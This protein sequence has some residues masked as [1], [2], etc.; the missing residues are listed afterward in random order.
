MRRIIL[1]LAWGLTACI[2]L[3]S[4]VEGPESDA[5]QKPSGT[6]TLGLDETANC[7]EGEVGW[8]FATT[9]DP[10]STEYSRQA[11]ESALVQVAQRFAVSVQSSTCAGDASEYDRVVRE[12]EGDL[13]CRFASTCTGAFEVVYTCGASD[14]DDDDA[15]REYTA[16]ASSGVV[17]LACSQPAQA[18]IEQE[19][20]TACIPRECHGRARR[21]LNMNCV[22][23]PT[24][25]DVAVYAWIGQPDVTYIPT[26]GV[27]PDDLWNYRYMSKTALTPFVPPQGYLD[28]NAL[29]FAH[30]PLYP[31]MAY[32]LLLNMNFSW[33]IMPSRSTVV[34]WIDDEYRNTQTGATERGFRC[35][36]FTKD[37]IPEIAENVS[38]GLTHLV[39]Y[40]GTF[41]KACVEGD[42]LSEDNAAKRL[43]LTVPA[44]RES[45]K[46]KSS[47]LRFSYDMEGRT[48]LHKGVSMAD[49][50]A[51]ILAYNTPEC[52]PNPQDFYYNATTGTYDLIAY[53]SQRE[54]RSMPIV[55]VNEKTPRRAHIIPGPIRAT[56]DLTI[57]TESRLNASLPIDLEWKALNFNDDNPFNPF[58]KGVD[59]G[60]AWDERSPWPDG[61]YAAENVR[62]SIFVLPYGEYGL[63]G[64]NLEWHYKFPIGE[65]KLQNPNPDGTTESVNL[66]IT[67]RIKRYFT[68][69][70]S[71]A[72]VEGDSRLFSLFYCIESD[73]N[74]TRPAHGF[75][76][77]E[78][79]TGVFTYDRE[80]NQRDVYAKQ[81]FIVQNRAESGAAARK[82]AYSVELD[83][84][85]DAMKNVFF[86]R[87]YGQWGHP[88]VPRTMRGCRQART[89]LR[90]N[91]DR[92]SSPLEPIAS[93]GFTGTTDNSQ[94]GDAK[95]SGSNDNDTQIDCQGAARDNCVEAV[96][97]G[98][99]TD[100]Q[101]GRSTFDLNSRLG[102][103]PGDTAS[104]SM[105]GELLGFQLLD[106]ADPATSSVSYPG[107][108]DTLS[109]TPVTITLAPD[110][111][112]LKSQ[113]QFATQGTRATW[114]K[115]RYAG[116]M[117]LGVGWGYK[118]VFGVPPKAILV[119]FSFTVGVSLALEAE[120]QFAPTSEQAYP[121]IGTKSCIVKIDEAKTF[122]GA[123]QDCN[124][125]GGRL[126]EL[127]SMAEALEVE[128][129]MGTD[130]IWLG[131]QLAYRHPVPSCA[132]NFNASQCTPTSST[133]FRWLSNSAA[134]ASNVGTSAPTYHA[135]HL[136]RASSAGLQT[137]YPQSSAVIYKPDG[138][139]RAAPVE[140]LK[141]YLCVYEPA[142][143]QRFLRWQL[144]LKTGA[145][146]GFNLTG[147][148]PSDNPGFCLG[149]GFNVV[150]LSIGPVYESLYHWLYRAGEDSPYT[151]RGNTNISVPWSLK[152]FEGNVGASFNFFWFSV[153]YNLLTYD[154]ITADEG[155]LY[156]AD[157][158]VFESLQ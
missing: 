151:R 61:N 155:K 95:M 144:A 22:E 64:S 88:S 58:A 148:W 67:E 80:G 107:D 31:T 126:A 110:W 29:T 74:P 4:C 39:K 21:D 152:L 11:G 119:T 116:Q 62:A 100:G 125:R 134:F 34:A 114:D 70:F 147:C 19:T 82:V 118:Q 136:H 135:A 68:T 77:R 141:P 121:C 145:A 79:A 23:D 139:F 108:L 32:H 48:A 46:Y 54:V 117:G 50:D 149:A 104:A 115:G 7:P 157:T 154:G 33:G 124:V 1:S 60:G 2:G 75:Q 156:D 120:F 103:K 127:S 13:S 86:N 20:R 15:Q 55:F 14:R 65:I 25:T 102:R 123:A 93:A 92:F 63:P 106:P 98:N 52:A 51:N 30:T 66:P 6:S 97:G 8:R 78:G 133:E 71:G 47:T 90:V 81:N 69:P 42:R 131:A 9:L 140:T 113:L 101:N 91:V 28:I 56:Q 53:Y 76:P 112:S 18:A 3:S 105:S 59:I 24:I 36:A 143:K 83:N 12:C 137:R 99:R 122:R 138:T 146:A 130:E 109:S 132:T 150:A 128:N 158:P 5:F 72:Y 26:E 40:E 87:R 38:E 111:D 96:N 10:N 142:A 41:S 16:T 84:D 73:V 17:V 27:S 129:A 44:F 57:R 89:P 37:L 153:S 45:Y 94:T 85:Y 35:L 43:G 49:G